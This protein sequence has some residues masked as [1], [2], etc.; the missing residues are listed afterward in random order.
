MKNVYMAPGRG[1]D[2]ASAAPCGGPGFAMHHREYG[3]RVCPGKGKPC[4]NKFT[5]NTPN[6]KYCEECRKPKPSRFEWEP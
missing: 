1:I 5:P 6:G 4:G 3:Q 2:S